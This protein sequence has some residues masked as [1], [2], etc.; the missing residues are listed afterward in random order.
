[1]TYFSP[2]IDESGFHMPTYIDIKQELIK[3]AQDIFGQDIY[4]GEDSQDYQWIAIISEKLYDAFQISQQVYNNRA[5]NTAIGPALDSIVK[6]NGIKRKAAT[7]SKCDVIISGLPGTEIKNGIVVD[8]GNI[9]WKLPLSVKIPDSGQ[10]NVKAICKIEGPI[11]SNPGEL[12]GIYNP[13]YGWNGVYNPK[14][15]TL[16]SCIEDDTKLR[17]R[18]SDSTAQPSQSMLEGTSGAVAKLNDVTRSKVYENDTNE[19]NALGLPAH[20]ITVVVEGGEDK[21]I[22]EAI[23]IHKGPGCYTNGDV[24]IDIEDSKHQITSIRYFRP[25]YIDIDVTVNIKSLNGY[26][27][28]TT[29]SIKKNLQIYLN[30]MDIGSELAISSLWGIAL[31]AMPNLMNP[32]FSITSITASKHGEVQ[33]TSD[34]KLA[35]N[36]VCRGNINYITAN[37]T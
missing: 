18:Q 30:S 1:M 32:L 14:N 21:K 11:V 35:F 10:I 2:Y 20:S 28:A 31:Q 33:T 12:I 25:K 34:I 3:Y 5:P 19:V 22:A 9:K 17:K 37:V 4:L 15:G 23:W 6:I 36:E 27:T 16:G 8:K 26:T 29:D 7:Y 24:I 13:T